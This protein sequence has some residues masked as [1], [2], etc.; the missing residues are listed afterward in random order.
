MRLIL[1][2]LALFLAAPAFAASPADTAFE[3]LAQADYDWSQA[4]RGL[5]DGED[6]D[7]V[8]PQLADVKPVAQAKRLAVLEGYARTLASIDTRTLSPARQTD[9]AIY[10]YQLDTRIDRLRFR[11]WEMPFNSDSSF[12]GNLGYTSARDFKTEADYRNWIAQLRQLPAWFADQTANMRAGLARGFTPPRMTLAGREASLDAIADASDPTAT[13]LYKPFKTMPA[14]MAPATAAEL[15]A[16]AAQA[17]RAAI[18]AYAALRTFLKTDYIPKSRTTISAA[19]LPDGDAFYRAQIAE[20]ATVAMTP[21]EIHAIGLA[22]IAAIRGRMNG[23]MAETGFKGDF[24]AFL[25]YLRSDPRFYA[26]TPEELLKQAAWIAKQMDGKAATWFGH[27][28]RRRFAIVPVPADIAPFYTAGR[29]GDGVYLLNT[30]DLPS[31][32]LYQLT[33]L[34]LHESAPGHAFQ[35]PLAR[36]N[37]D[38]LPFRR[39]LYISAYGEGWALYCETLGEEMGLYETPYDRFGMLSYQAWRA[40]RLVIDTGLHSM[41]WSREQAQ[42]YLR[43]NTALSPHEI[44]TEVDR[45][46][47]WPGQAL[48]YYLGEMAIRRGR[49]K[50]ETALRAKFNIRAFHDMVLALGSVPLPALDQAVDGFIASGGIGPYPK[51]E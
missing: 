20:F 47:S 44:E 46:I 26:K 12:W 15:R 39:N 16:Q 25:T 41:G 11:T 10:R 24:P 50:A 5:I 49:A 34:T 22:E 18:P 51:E 21:A 32:P 2:F 19:A 7:R 28:P 48:S 29:G 4:D 3:K 33:A 38:R 37:Q 17:I 8:A 42:A 35:I 27:L 14:G 1:P 43:D 13:S 40:A 30:Y 45:Y 6:D 31:R 9:A 36:E 23:V